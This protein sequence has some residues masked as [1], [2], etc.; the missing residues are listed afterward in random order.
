MN[1]QEQIIVVVITVLAII[2]II[3][4]IVFVINI[5]GDPKWRHYTNLRQATFIFFCGPGAWIIHFLFCTVVGIYDNAKPKHEL[6]KEW[7]RGQDENF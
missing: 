3:I 5:L 7:L 1:R 6:L 4:G 2:Y